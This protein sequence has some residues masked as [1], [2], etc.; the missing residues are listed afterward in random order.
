MFTLSI[1]L[2]IALYHLVENPVRHR[3]ILAV[4]KRL[5][6]SYGAGLALTVGFFILVIISD[7]LPQ[8]FPK[9]VVRIAA[10]VND[11]LPLLEECSFKCQT[12]SRTDDFCKI[13]VAGVAPKW[14]VYGDSHAWAAHSAFDEWL[15]LK[16]E[17]GLF[18]YK[19][20]CPPVVGLH[21]FG[22]KGECFAFNRAVANFVS[23]RVDIENVVLVSTWHQASE[24]RL[25]TSAEVQLS[26]AESIALFDEKFSRTLE[27]LYRKGKNIYVWEPVP[28]ARRSVPLALARAA[29]EN[30]D[31]DIE[32]TRAQY[33]VDNEFFFTAL[34][35][36]RQLI[37]VT[38][39]AL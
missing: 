36:N 4:D 31:A 12:L 32:L 30:R 28:G 21:V 19:T 26:V 5:L 20:S 29:L 22:G 11:K 2:A 10:F 34:A 16:G 37:A 9:D 13:G 1:G 38:F 35:K 14:L 15:K 24:A 18:A 7:G 3:R 33:R 25:S 6:H 17:A 39:L 27:D 8:R 23:E